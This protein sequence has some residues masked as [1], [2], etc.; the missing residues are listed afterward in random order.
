MRQEIVFANN[1][2]TKAATIY[3]GTTFPDI[4]FG[5]AASHTD[6]ANFF[7]G[8]KEVEKQVDEDSHIFYKV[9]GETYY[10]P[11]DGSMAFHAY[12]PFST[13]TAAWDGTN[14]TIAEYD[15]AAKQTDLLYATASKDISGGVTGE[16]PLNFNHTLAQIIFQFKKA[17]ILGST[18]VV[19]NHVY[20]KIPATVADFS[21]GT[22]SDLKTPKQ[23]TIAQN[24]T[25]TDTYKQADD[26][27]EFLVLPQALGAN[28]DDVVITVNYKTKWALSGW[29]TRT[30]EIKVSDLKAKHT[31]GEAR[32][33][34]GNKYIYK[35]EVSTTEILFTSSIN[36]D[37][38]DNGNVVY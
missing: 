3:E 37:W 13:A 2:S 27:D 16:L 15:V 36:S 4:T 22:W 19:I 28:D 17:T 31:G 38:V 6:E 11:K 20:V 25:C 21:N 24:Y 34:A 30:V 26:D 5:V 32:W 33:I 12:A 35:I 8:V 1:V 23:Y 9:K 14:L 10:W 7:G 18:Q 29:R